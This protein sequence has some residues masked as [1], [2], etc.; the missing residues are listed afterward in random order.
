[1]LLRLVVALTAFALWTVAVVLI[2][3]QTR[4]LHNLPGQGNLIWWIMAGLF[5]VVIVFIPFN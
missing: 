4:K 1:M 2:D 3:R 5:I